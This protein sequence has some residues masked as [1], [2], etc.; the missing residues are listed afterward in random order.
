MKKITF[1]Y[2]DE[3]TH[4]EWRE[5]TCIVPSVADCKGLYGLEQDDVEYE[6]ISVEEVDGGDWKI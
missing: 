5:Q 6:I 1:K 3:Y 4:G 2:R